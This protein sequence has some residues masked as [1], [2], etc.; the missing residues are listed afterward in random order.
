[1]HTADFSEFTGPA[2]AT[3][4]DSIQ[5]A[6]ECYHCGLPLPQGMRLAVLIDGTERPMCCAGCQAVAQTI[7]DNGLTSYYRHRSA[8]P[9]R[10]DS[11][12]AM[13]RDLA[14]YSIPEVESTVTSE[15]G[16]H[17]RATSL[18][19]EG[20][21]C[22]ACVWLIEQRLGRL[23]GVLAIEINYATHRAHLR[24]DT[25]STRLTAILDAVAA[26]GFRVYPYDSTR[27][28]QGRRS[29]RDRALWRLFV[30]GF[31][32]MQV[33][34][35][36]VPVYLTKG[37]MT[38][39]IE[40]LMRIAS[41]ILTLPV[42]LY[43]AA[44]FF[45][46]AW[47]DLRAGQPGMDVP[48]ALGIGVAFAASVVATVTGS[49]EV[50]FDSVTM[51]VFLLLAA[52]FLE[53]TARMKAVATQE[54]LA[55]QAPAVA[56]R[57]T[58]WQASRSE[59]IA[60][61]GLKAGDCVRVRPGAAVPA[62]GVVIAGES[63]LDERLLTGE[64][65]A[66]VKRL[67]DSLTGGSFNIGSPLV[68][69]VTRAGADTVL[70]GILRLL[71]RGAAERPRIA[72]SADRV[73]RYF[74]LGLL[75]LA[76]AV[77]AAWYLID[78]ARALWVTV[79]VLVVSCPC[80]LSL[81]TPAALAAATGALH[82]RGVLVTRGDAIENLAR[83]TH[84]VFD[85]T[86]TLTSGDMRLLGVIPLADGGN[87][88]TRE[89][90]LALAAALEG[91][92]SHPIARALVAAAPAAPGGAQCRSFP[93]AGV[94][95]T[96]NGVRVRL[97]SPQFVAALGAYALPQ[98]LAF[99]T[100]D[101]TVAALG[102]DAGWIALFTFVDPVRAQA[103]AVVNALTGMGRQVHMLSGDRPQIVAHVAHELGIVTF[104]GGA[105]PDGKLAYVQRLQ[106]DGAVVA[107]IGDGVNDAA[108]LAA[109]HVSIAMGGG[110]AIAS[111]NSDVVLLSGRLDALLAAVRV[112]DATLRVV[113]QNLAWAFAYNLA[114]IP[115]AA[116]GYVSPLVAGI[117]MAASST[118]VVANALRLLRS[119]PAPASAVVAQP[120]HA[121]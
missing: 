70:A 63:D 31:G 79:A 81:A 110:A 96:L 74:V 19:L 24:W 48:V 21:T 120:A 3:M 18:M 93:G 12:P 82:A 14:A 46:G 102:D 2:A 90:C 45:V 88:R 51:F 13:V 41:L 54:E 59:M 106:Q 16:E 33:M 4:P 73:A 86:G 109:A 118:L 49:G 119:A 15:T 95:T 52:R 66:Q 32:M 98:E 30:A 34:M 58:D 84:F 7:A 101:V 114:A 25:R 44:P 71:E 117:G 17:A 28:E 23:P 43:A 64:S 97:G 89:E 61:A 67:G 1:M 38:P 53:M 108:G 8:L 87:R 78:P 6:T 107:M 26:L 55:R 36:L 113:R 85:K 104:L 62:D 42:V 75:V 5:P 39:D 69:R 99:V 56:E 35:Y 20:I 57:L 100:D 68:M 121:E 92:F 80:A 112:A 111:G 10:E 105:T 11:V 65:R 91:G 103:R 9:L 22:A 94:E 115:L 50:Y 60:A 47:R 37:E 116:G 27:A 77:A 83:A 76:A 40:Q 29:G 72:R